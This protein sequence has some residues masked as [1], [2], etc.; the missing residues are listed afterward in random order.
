MRDSTLSCPG[1]NDDVA[2]VFAISMAVAGDD[3]LYLHIARSD[4]AGFEQLPPRCKQAVG[5]D[6]G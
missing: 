1:V 6:A 4:D 5:L 3:P 2:A